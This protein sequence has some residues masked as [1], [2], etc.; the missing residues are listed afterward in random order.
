MKKCIL[1]LFVI[2]SGLGLTAQE[3]GNDAHMELEADNTRKAL[4]L[5]NIA[6]EQIEKKDFE[7]AIKSC[8]EGL[9]LDDE[10]YYLQGNLAHAYLLSGNYDDAISIYRKYYGKPF[11]E[12]MSWKEMI[13]TDFEAFRSKGFDATNMDK[14]LKDLQSF[15]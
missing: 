11:S 10:N 3:Q 13:K 8:K 14:A 15:E 7:A 1:I 2:V 5:A 4:E 9:A 6:W 12:T